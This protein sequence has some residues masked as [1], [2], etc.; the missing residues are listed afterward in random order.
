MVAKKT[1]PLRGCY[2]KQVEI[3]EE[4]ESARPQAQYLK[5]EIL[6]NQFVMLM[7]RLG[8][9]SV[10]VASAAFAQQGVNAPPDAIFY[11]GKI[12]TVDAAFTIQ[13]A[14]AVKGDQYAAVGSNARIRALAGRNTRMVD[15]EGAAVIPGLS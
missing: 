2:R 15:L 5:T 4:P 7:L 1:G 8:L 14:F 3:V 13:Q 10:F 6:A 9:L 12:V 11:N